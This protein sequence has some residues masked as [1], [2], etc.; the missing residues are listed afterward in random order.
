[1]KQVLAVC[2]SPDDW[3]PDNSTPYEEALQAAGIEPVLIAPGDK[4]PSAFPGL[5]LMGGSDV[6]PARYGASRHPDTETSDDARDA[7]EIELIRQALDFD[8][9]LLAICRGAQILNVQHG[10]TL[11]QHLASTDRHRRRTPDRALPV[12]KI[13]IAPGTKLAEIAGISL[14]QDVNSRHHQAI[15]RVG[16]GLVVSARDPGDRVIEAVE[17]PDKRFVIGVQWHPENQF[18]SDERQANLFR[19]FAAML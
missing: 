5:L 17:R 1:M 18:F 2:G 11:I 14:I 15:D 4:I 3:K 8:I 12:H 13:Q 16:E 7:L 9:P 19:K 10:G 6:N